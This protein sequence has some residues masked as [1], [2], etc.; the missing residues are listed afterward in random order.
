MSAKIMISLYLL[1]VIGI[2]PRISVLAEFDSKAIEPLKALIFSYGQRLKQMDNFL[3]QKCKQRSIQLY[4][5]DINGQVVDIIHETNGKRLPSQ[6][7]IYFI[8]HDIGE[9][10]QIQQIQQL[11]P[12]IY[13]R[14]PN[15]SLVLSLD[16]SAAVSETAARHLTP[17]N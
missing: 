16:W 10:A 9:H 14:N 8:A 3:N 13:Q 2:I 5:L 4:V 7:D 11:V 17:D 15:D 12:K 1:V 6:K